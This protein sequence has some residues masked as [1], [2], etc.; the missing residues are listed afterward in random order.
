MRRAAAGHPATARAGPAGG[1]DRVAGARR[2]AAA[3]LHA[4][5]CRQPRWLSRRRGAQ[6]SAAAGKAA[7]DCVVWAARAALRGDIAALVTA[8]LHKQALAAA[9][10]N[11]PGHTELLQ[12]EAAAW[13]G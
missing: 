3:A 11:F 12:A 10:V 7:A 2:L 1:A 4:A 5:C 6:V 9:G 13:L 8:P